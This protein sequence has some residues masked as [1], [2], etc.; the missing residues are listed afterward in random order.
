MLEY[1]FS[2]GL[3]DGLFIPDPDS[4]GLM[5]LGVCLA[6]RGILKVAKQALTS[7]LTR[8]NINY[9]YLLTRWSTIILPAFPLP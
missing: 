1:G 6:G 3:T 4:G 7:S 5:Y 9:W 8:C 2:R